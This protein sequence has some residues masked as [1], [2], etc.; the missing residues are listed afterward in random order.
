MKKIEKYYEKTK[1]VLPHKNVK[2]FLKIE[3]KKGKAIDLGCGAGR[4]TIFL[5]KNNWN[6][7]AIDREDT[8]DIISSK[9]NDEELRRFRFN[10]QDFENIKLEENDLIVANFSLPFCNKKDFKEFWNTIVGSILEDG[11]FVGT[12]LGLNDS[13]VDMKENVVFLSKEQVLELF[14]NSFEIIK[15]EEIEKDEKT[16]LGKLKHWHIYEIIAKKRRE[17]NK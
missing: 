12:F 5:I 6:V 14:E 9:L 17:V 11:Y 10:R 13:W 2:E 16:A 1:G 15:F 8:K 3:N 7:L 4:D